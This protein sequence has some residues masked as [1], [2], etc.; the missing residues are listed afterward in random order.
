MMKEGGVAG[1]SLYRCQSSSQCG[2]C[3]Q[4]SQAGALSCRP[5]SSSLLSPPSPS[6]LSSA[7][8]GL[9]LAQRSLCCTPESP[10]F[11]SVLLSPLHLLFLLCSL[12]F[13]F[14]SLPS[15]QIWHNRKNGAGILCLTQGKTSEGKIESEG[16][17]T[18]GR[19][20]LWDGQRFLPY[21]AASN[22][23]AHHG[24]K[25]QDGGACFNIHMCTVSFSRQVDRVV[26]AQPQGSSLTP[27]E[28]MSQNNSGGVQSYRQHLFPHYAFPRILLSRAG[29]QSG[30]SSVDV[31]VWKIQKAAVG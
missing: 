1:A 23:K 7:W 19:Y 22:P 5:S 11:L 31:F 26:L 16:E 25:S 27:F 18:E 24:P 2:D 4:G 8:L 14:K 9:A 3:F 13:S 20:C 29:S 28:P 17:K 10:S 21:P 30:T 6:T 15:S 12:R